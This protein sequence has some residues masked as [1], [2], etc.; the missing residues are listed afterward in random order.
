M[1]QEARVK[2]KSPNGNHST[3]NKELPS[4]EIPDTLLS[5]YA[6]EVLFENIY[7]NIW[8]VETNLP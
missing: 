7:K 2:M 3:G 5:L 8:S 1:K 4:R 6:V